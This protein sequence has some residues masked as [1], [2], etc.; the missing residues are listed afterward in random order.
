[1]QDS[2]ITRFLWERACPRRNQ[3]AAWHRLRRC[4]RA[5]P[6]PQVTA[7]A[8]QIWRKTVAPASTAATPSQRRPLW[9]R[10]CPRTPAQPVPGTAS[11]ASRACPLPQVNR[12]GFSNFEKDS[13]SCKYGG[14]SK[15]AQALWERACPRTPAQ[16]V[17]DP[18]S[19]ASRACPLP[20]VNSAGFSNFEKDSCSCKYGGNS[21]PAQTP[22]GAG[23]PANTGA[24]G[25]RSRVACFA[26]LPAPTGESRRLFKF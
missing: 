14:N 4:S 19:P 7:S 22:V 8:F 16:P 17:P 15:P 26:G 10:A 3:R 5:C 9:E 13:C 23:M 20:Q 6:L 21:K 25:A 1:M 24:A 2:K 18:A 11:P 12:A